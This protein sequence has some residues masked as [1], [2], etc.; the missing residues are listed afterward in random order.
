MSA[1]SDPNIAIK[2][3]RHFNR[4]YTNRLGLLSRY[5][6][7]TEFTLT[8][9]RVLFEVGRRGEHTQKALGTELKL[10]LGYLNRIVKKL[11][12][13]GL[14]TVLKDTNDG[15]ARALRVTREGR[16]ALDRIDV[17]SDAEV[18]GLIQDLAGDEVTEFVRNLRAAEAILERRGTRRPI[19]TAITGGPEL[20]TV[21]TLLREYLEFLDADLSFQ[22]IDAELAEL[23]GKYAPPAGAL[24]LASM[25]MVEGGAEPAGCVAL[26]KLDEQTCEMKRLFVRP[27]FRGTGL[28]RILADRLVQEARTL[29]YSRM[30]LDT[31]ERLGDAVGLYQSM[32]FHTIPAYCENP[33]PGAL[34]WELDL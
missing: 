1:P 20:E 34:F 30:R 26:R 14:I 12:A 31:L 17:S 13:K 4:Y 10:D 19:L 7:D 25:P 11:A 6:L 8:E 2:A 5:R 16:K 21:R 3:I 9:A 28:G 29:G 24:F 18:K 22:H 27:E 15:R 23:P 33:L 32:G